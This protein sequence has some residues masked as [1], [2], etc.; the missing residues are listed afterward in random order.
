[1]RRLNRDESQRTH[2]ADV[3]FFD[4]RIVR[5]ETEPKKRKRRDVCNWPGPRLFAMRKVPISRRE[6]CPRP[7]TR[8]TALDLPVMRVE[9]IDRRGDRIKYKFTRR[10][11]IASHKS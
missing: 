1:M 8:R 11:K 4:R 3:H 7:P 2:F 5:R 9:R 6:G 10:R